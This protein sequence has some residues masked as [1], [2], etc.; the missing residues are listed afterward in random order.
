[1]GTEEGGMISVCAPVR[2]EI[3]FI[4]AWYHN[5]LSYADELV[6]IDTGSTDGTK[7]WLWDIKDFPGTRLEWKIDRAYYWPEAQIRN[8]GIRHCHGDWIVDQ[9]A[10]DLVTQGFL[11]ALPEL[12]SSTS[13]F[14]WLRYRTF[15]ISPNLIRVSD[16][17]RDGRRWDPVIRPQMFRNRESIRFKRQ[18]GYPTENHCSLNWHGLGKH[19]TL[20]RAEFHPEIAVNHYHYAF[21]EKECDQY[22][23]TRQLHY[24]GVRCKTYFGPHP[25]EVK[26]YGWWKE[27]L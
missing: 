27:L 16:G 10:D 17:T 1:M 4:E 8:L 5:A 19:S 23:E 6:V 14:H 11:D 7:E 21:R 9:D 26:Y 2:N 13:L 20:L 3:A 15:W 25:P 22:N 18:R 24:D 12:T